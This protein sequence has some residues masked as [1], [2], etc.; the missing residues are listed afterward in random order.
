MENTWRL[1]I[2][3]G[4]IVGLALAVILI[5]A[6]VGLVVAA[7]VT[8]VSI[9]VFLLGLGACVTLG[10]AIRV[11]TQLWGLINAS[12][13]L[14]RN[15]LV[16]H[17][18]PIEHQIPMGSIRDVISG[19]KL[20]NVR[21]RPSL[22]WPGYVVALGKA[23]APEGDGEPDETRSADLDPILFYASAPLR[24]QVILRTDGITYAISPE[25]TEAFLVA[26]RE[27]L[28]M[29]PTQEVEEHSTHPAFLDWEIWRDRWSLAMLGCSVGLLILMVGV[30]CWRFPYLSAEIPLKFAPDGSILL[31]G[32][33]ARIFYFAL[34][35]TAFTVTNVGLGLFFYRRQRPLSYF[36]WSGLLAVLGGLWAAVVSILLRQ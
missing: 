20:E 18:G 12:Y 27:R 6:T 19:A 33:R 25:D 7:V 4:W 30:L 3:T 13:E 17:W 9:R 32:G 14:D 21:I 26:L 5:G 35:G 36:L 22:R 28:E 10:L 2:R 24:H 15:A 8:P 11:L 16:I 31:T 29:G 34:V 1:D 23:T